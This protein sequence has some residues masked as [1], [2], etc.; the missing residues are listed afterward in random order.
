MTP[1]SIK[2]FSIVMGAVSSAPASTWP[3]SN[4]V[5]EEHLSVILACDGG[6]RRAPYE[7]VVERTMP[8]PALKGLAQN[9][10]VPEW[11]SQVPI[12][13]TPPSKHEPVVK[14]DQK[15][16]PRPDQKPSPRPDQKPEPKSDQKPSPKSG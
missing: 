16:S 13:R 9:N 8:V 14:P 4:G 10:P 1:L 3:V 15:P 5:T 6:P 12:P 7:R 2:L 11:V